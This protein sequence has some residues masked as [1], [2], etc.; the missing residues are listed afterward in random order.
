MLVVGEG[1]SWAVICGSWDEKIDSRMEW[2]DSCSR[3]YRTVIYGVLQWLVRE[4][5]RR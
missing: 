2:N 5:V 3:M 4:C 1:K